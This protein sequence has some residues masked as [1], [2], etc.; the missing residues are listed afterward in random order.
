MHLNKASTR[1]LYGFYHDQCNKLLSC[2]LRKIVIP[3]GFLN[4]QP[5]L[6]LLR[7]ETDKQNTQAQ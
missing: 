3:L 1:E 7:E 5:L 4:L 2:H 6:H